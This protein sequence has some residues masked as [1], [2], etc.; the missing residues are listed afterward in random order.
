MKKRISMKRL[1]IGVGIFANKEVL[2]FH[3]KLKNSFTESRISWVRPENMHITLNFI[4]DTPE[5]KIPQ[6]IESL[7]RVGDSSQRFNSQIKSFGIFGR[8]G[9]PKVF[10]LGTDHEDEWNSLYN[11][12]V[13]S[14]PME[15]KEENF[16]AHLTLARIKFFNNDS[17]AL[18]S[19][20]EN[21]KTKAFQEVNVHHFQL[22]QSMLLPT[23]PRYSVIREFELK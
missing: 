8:S 6:I 22:Y 2:E 3:Q 23:G 13:R 4:G 7:E 14:L 11:K 12:I 15:E 9:N 17:K 19:Y 20:I 16:N 21:Y 1:F 10:W 18:A 5:Q